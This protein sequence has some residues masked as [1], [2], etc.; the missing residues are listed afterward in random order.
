MDTPVIVVVV[1]IVSLQPHT[2]CPGRRRTVLSV[3]LFAGT[4]NRSCD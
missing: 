2:V 1:S 4:K 3:R